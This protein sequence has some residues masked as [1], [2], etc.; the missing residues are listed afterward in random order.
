MAGSWFCL[1]PGTELPTLVPFASGGITSVPVRWSW[2]ALFPPPGRCGVLFIRAGHSDGPDLLCYLLNYSSPQC[3]SPQARRPL[4]IGRADHLGSAGQCGSTWV[5]KHSFLKVL[6]STPGCQGDQTATLS[7]DIRD[8]LLQDLIYQGGPRTYQ[9]AP[10]NPTGVSI[11]T[12]RK[13]LA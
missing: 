4:I 9:R 8:E 6:G 1:A 3:M 10:A 12:L 13:F 7:T 11:A 2:D 5:Q